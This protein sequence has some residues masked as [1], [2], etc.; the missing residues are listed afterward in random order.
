MA[1]ERGLYSTNSIIHSVYYLY[2]PHSPKKPTRQFEN[3][4]SAPCSIYVN[5]KSSNV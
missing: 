2:A 1:T 3:T 4:Q 5:A